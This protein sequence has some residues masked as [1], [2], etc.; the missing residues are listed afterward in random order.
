MGINIYIKNSLGQNILHVTALYGHTILCRTRLDKYNFDMHTVDDNGWT[1]LH[2]SARN[3][4]YELFSFF[5]DMG[6]DILVKDNLGRNC[7]HN[8]ALWGH[9]NLC[10]K[11]M[12]KHKLD[13]NTATNEGWTA[14][15]NLSKINGTYVLFKLFTDM[16]TDI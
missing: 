9:F 1:A 4:S 7:L 12:N 15:F 8:A 2:Y 10:K 14:L 3:G 11:P 5:M 13:V 6:T 16:G